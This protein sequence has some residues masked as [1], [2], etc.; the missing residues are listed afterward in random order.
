MWAMV[1]GAGLLAGLASFGLGEATPA[2]V[3]PSADLP[4]EIASSGQRAAAEMERRMS[5]SRDQVATLAYGGLGMVLGLALGAAGGLSRRS[6]RGA[7]TAAVVGAIAGG[8]A[9]AGATLALLPSY[10]AER[11]AAADEDATNDLLLALRTHGGIWVAV[12]AA[13]GLA[14]GLGLGGGA[15]T[16]KAL[17]GGILGAAL[18]AAIYE[19][20]GALVFPTSQTFRPV[21]PSMGPR[22]LAHLG[23]AFGVA[24][25]A[26]W[27]AHHLH[28]RRATP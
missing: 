17:V 21:A 18:A 7:I 13:A 15:R 14:L 27:A 28:L 6:A 2:L 9:G 10:H 25:V 5:R 26:C 8:A 22:L 12:G 23:V 16:A 1:L 4:P 19:F 11:A 3:P 24:G 20:A